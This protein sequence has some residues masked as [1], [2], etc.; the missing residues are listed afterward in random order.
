MAT[1]GYLTSEP[2]DVLDIPF[3][4]SWQ[5]TS[6]AVRCVLGLDEAAGVQ[7]TV[8]VAETSTTTAFRVLLGQWVSAPTVRAGHL[9]GVVQ[10]LIVAEES[11]AAANL[12]TQ[13]AVRVVSGDGSV[14]RGA[15]VQFNATEWPTVFGTIITG[16][17]TIDF[18]VQRGDRLVVEVGYR[19]GNVAITSYSGSLLYGGA[20]TDSPRMGISDMAI[21]DLFSD[22]GTPFMTD[23][24]GKLPGAEPRMVVELAWGADLSADPVTWTWTDITG[25]VRAN[26]RIE[27]SVGRGDEASTA[28]PASAALTLDN[29]DGLYSL[30]TQSPNWPNVR[31]GTPVRVRVELTR[32]DGWQT[33]FEGR[34]N[35]FTPSWDLTGT[36]AVVKLSASGVRRRIAQGIAPLGSSMRRAIEVLDSGVVA[37]WPFEDGPKASS[38]A[39]ATRGTPPMLFANPP[40][41]ASS[42]EFACSLPLPKVRNVPISGVIPPY[43]DTGE[44][45]LRFLMFG[46]DEGIWENDFGEL[47]NVWTSGTIV[48]WQ[49]RYLLTPFEGSDGLGS[50]G[51][52]GYNADGDT[53]VASGSLNVQLFERPVQVSIEINQAGPDID[54]RLRVL[55]VGEV[56][57]RSVSGTV[58]DQTC[59]QFQRIVISPSNSGVINDL[60]L[61]HLVVQNQLTANLELAEP[62]TSYSG[63]TPPARI[64]RLCAENNIPVEVIG[65]SVV[66]MGPQGDG[67]L[68]DLLRDA[69]VADQG[70]LYDG[71]G[72]GFT[73]VTGAVRAN[74]EPILTINA[75]AGQLAKELAPADDDQRTRNLYAAEREGGSSYTFEDVDGPQGTGQIGVYDDSITVNID[76]DTRAQD[77]AAWLVHLGTIA[78]YRYP[79]ILLNLARTPELAA[80]WMATT[81]SGRLAIEGIATG[82]PQHPAAPLSLLVE[83]WSESIDQ[84]TWEVEVTCTIAEGWR[85]GVVAADTG[86]TSEY[87]L[88]ASPDGATLAAPVAQGATSLSVATPAGR[89]LWTTAAD[90]LPLQIEVA[91]IPVTVTAIGAGPSPQTF[92]VDPATVTKAL[93]SVAP[94]ELWRTPVLALL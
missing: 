5:D 38:L 35:G 52:I 92:T 27:S 29:R 9:R 49:V 39:A 4:A 54:W 45:Q 47:L 62:L 72:P 69:E 61:G 31:R 64:A 66:T 56:T 17:P 34:A 19:A 77:Y 13:Y 8:T 75:S 63:E 80:A 90:D 26:G 57:S 93:P 32:D 83:G 65:E 68:L 37:Y 40:E 2:A 21:V 81:L 25:D 55:G 73:Y 58:E 20:S 46:A 22:V 42:T 11:D 23:T 12:Q 84:Y 67:E 70:V 16:Q 76:S 3:D 91:G 50:L 89:P 10:L 88:R 7:S 33:R 85:T 82:R 86:D 6:G 74:A 59:G 53:L 30:G 51:L 41:L 24:L 15:L 44:N 60:A 79:R 14:E 36:D 78:G 43:T 94:V 48:A 71:P 87:V 18:E 1:I 28:Q